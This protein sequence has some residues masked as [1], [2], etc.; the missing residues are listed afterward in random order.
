MKQAVIAIVVCTAGAGAVYGALFGRSPPE[1]TATDTTVTTLSIRSDKSGRLPRLPVKTVAERENLAGVEDQAPDKTIVTSEIQ[2]AASVM[3]VPSEDLTLGLQ[4]L[5]TRD[6]LKAMGYRD[7][8]AANS[9]ER[10][11][12]T[13][14]IAV[15]GQVAVPS[16]ELLSARE[17][18]RDWPAAGDIDENLE[19]ALYRENADPD[20]VLAAFADRMPRTAEGAVIL[21][22]A[23]LA[24]GDKPR[25][26]RILKSIWHEKTFEPAL[27]DQILDEFGSLIDDTDHRQRMTHLLFAEKLTQAKRFS[28]MLKAD[29]L[30]RA[31]SAV[32]KKSDDSKA[33]LKAVDKKWQSDPAYLYASI[34]RLRQTRQYEEAAK[35]IESM[36]RDRS[37]LGDADAWWVEAR[38]VSRGLMDQGMAKAAYALAISHL[39]VSPDD[40]AEAEFHAG[41][42]ALRGL[43]DPGQAETHFKNL[44]SASPKA[45]DQARGYYWLGRA[46]A[47]G[48]PGDANAFYAK[49]ADYPATF[50]GQLAA[51][52]LGTPVELGARY[53]PTL[54]IQA[55]FAKRPEMQAISLFEQ[56]GEAGRARR[57]YLALARELDS[58]SEL[59]ALAEIALK[60]HGPSLA[61][62]IGKAA[63]RQGH[64]PGLAAFPLGAIPDTAD[65]SGAGKAL[66]YAI[67]RQES[68]FNPS[69]VSP[70]N[71]RGLLQLL[72]STAK[73][74][75]SRYQMAYADEKL[76]DDPAFNATLGS[77][78]LGEQ[79]SKFSGSY[80]LTFAAYNAGPGRIPQ[81]IKRYGD[82]RGKPIDEVVD[83]IENIPFTETRDYVQRVMEN[84]QVYKS[85]L[86]EPAD[87]AADL[88]AGLR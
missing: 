30:Y 78:Y 85:L 28:D 38:I 82:P 60:N 7:A 57:L 3:P 15:S 41:W 37:M 84:Y 79:I 66:A 8:M 39:A 71:A 87:I 48:G 2:V 35:L 44:V 47:A 19:E 26:V 65:I 68:A 54:E 5:S 73:K 69:A 62:A 64:D 18:L 42:Y 80:I 29:S 36:P 52:K 13:W 56:T 63:L 4:A 6:S 25:A 12:L 11:T 46:A 40:I 51:A 10:M 31:F 9:T 88:T 22:R 55:T 45:H 16:S 17:T 34:K 70:A 1:P 21:A 33:L 49:A 76:I 75:A 53:N 27:E 23:S 43:N 81:W 20:Q 50:Y 14:A 59:Q 72:P 77:H 58:P 74:V 83:W 32:V 24:K 86:N 61:L 67:A